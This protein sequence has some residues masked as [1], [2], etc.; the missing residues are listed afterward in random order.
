MQRRG[1]ILRST[2]KAKH[3]RPVPSGAMVATGVKSRHLIRDRNDEVGIHLSVV[4]EPLDYSCDNIPRRSPH[5]VGN[6]DRVL[7]PSFGDSSLR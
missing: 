7:D 6:Y 1:D 2:H 3:S 5:G 4:D